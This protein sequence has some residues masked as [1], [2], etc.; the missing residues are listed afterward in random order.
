MEELFV[1]EESLRDFEVL[2]DDDA[3]QILAL[4]DE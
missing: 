3:L 1:M 2:F 4:L